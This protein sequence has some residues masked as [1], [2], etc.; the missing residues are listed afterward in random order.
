[1]RVRRDSCRRGGPAW[2]PWG[3]LKK[4]GGHAGPPL[5]RRTKQIPVILVI[6]FVLSVWASP[7]AAQTEPPPPLPPPARVVAVQGVSVESAAILMS[8]QEGGEI[9]L[10]A[11]ALPIRDELDKTRVLLRLRL[12]G[13]ALLAGQT[14]DTLRAEVILYALDA[15]NGVQASLLEAIEVDLAAYRGAIERNGIDHLASLPLQPGE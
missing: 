10:G 2:P 4:Q 8:G 12:D 11:L 15:G 1:M 14:A 7:A 6:L 3:G 9:S 13:P 5:R